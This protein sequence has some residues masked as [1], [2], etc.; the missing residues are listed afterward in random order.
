M[1]ERLIHFAKAPLS[2]VRH[3]EQDNARGHYKPRGLWVSVEGNGDGW[4]DWCQGQRY[5]LDHLVHQNEIR[6]TAEAKILRLVCADD[7]DD[8]GTNFRMPRPL[9]TYRMIDWEAVARLYQGII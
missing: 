1:G 5:G 8:F 4:F 7:L 3:V 9:S 2:A 6:L